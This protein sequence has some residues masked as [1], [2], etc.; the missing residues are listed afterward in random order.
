MSALFIGERRIIEWNLVFHKFM[1]KHSL[2][3]LAEALAV[4][5]KYLSVIQ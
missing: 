3:L 2:I 1:N 4:T 5:W